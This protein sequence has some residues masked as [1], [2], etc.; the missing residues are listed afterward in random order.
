VKAEKIPFEPDLDN[1]SVGSVTAILF[2]GHIR[3]GYAPFLFGGREFLRDV[4]EAKVGQGKQY[5]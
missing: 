2:M 3:K 4:T 5:N 1:A